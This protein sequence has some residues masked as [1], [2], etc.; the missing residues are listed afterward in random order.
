MLLLR[1]ACIFAGLS[2]FG[3][4]I[5]DNG[6]HS[7]NSGPQWPIKLDGLWFW[8]LERADASFEHR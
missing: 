1:L 6:F 8:T 3:G 2:L 4:G 7:L 5:S